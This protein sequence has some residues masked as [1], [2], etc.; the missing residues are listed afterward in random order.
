MFMR[1]LLMTMIAACAL[2]LP[3]FAQDATPAPPAPA[4]AQPNN[5]TAASTQPTRI[6]PG[7]VIPVQLT[8]SVDAKKVKTGD[9]VDVKVT[10][11]MKTQSG[12]VLIPKDTRIVGHVTEAQGR[13]KEQ[14][15]SQLGITFDHAVL[16][17]GGDVPLPASIQAVIVPPSQNPDN[18]GSSAGGGAPSQA[19]SGGSP[20]TG[21][22]AGMP[23]GGSSPQAPASA[24]TAG[25]DQSN[26]PA[27]N[28]PNPQITSS[29][30]GVIGIS[31]YKLS[32]PGDVTQGSS[33]RGSVVSSE[34]S[35]V[36]LESGTLMLL[37]VNQ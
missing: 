6:A 14:K 35:N 24:P 3:S 15:E 10:Q 7:S 34:K 23:G 18:A 31:N 12:Q 28:A 33:S 36:K 20:G 19:P 2:C 16:K 17:E 26:A 1:I 4:T 13:S 27:G 30:Q 8:K 37:R 21:N 25:G 11:D 5:R 32:T 22:R 29:T 9:E